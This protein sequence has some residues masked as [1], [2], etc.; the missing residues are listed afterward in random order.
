M[1]FW[2]DGVNVIVIRYDISRQW[3]YFCRTE[4]HTKNM[5]VDCVLIEKYVNSIILI[6]I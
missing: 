5:F 1:F 6:F 3:K 4:E 2:V